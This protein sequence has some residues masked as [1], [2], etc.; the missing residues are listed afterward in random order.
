VSTSDLP[1]VTLVANQSQANLHGTSSS[2]KLVYGYEWWIATGDVSVIRGILPVSWAV[3]CA[4]ASW[5]DVVGALKWKGKTF[6]KRFDFVN[7]SL[8][9]TDSE[10]NRGIRGFSSIWG[11]EVEMWFG[12][13]DLIAQ[14]SEGP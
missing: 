14:N 6:C 13:N 8:L 7:Q 2:S 3:W 1:E 4:M 10:K 9:L 12:T 5:K 11:C